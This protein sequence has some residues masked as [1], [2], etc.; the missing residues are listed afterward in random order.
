MSFLVQVISK[1]AHLRDNLARLLCIYFNGHANRLNQT[2]RK[3]ER[4]IQIVG[5]RIHVFLTG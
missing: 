1:K 2:L 5:T 3:L 4:A